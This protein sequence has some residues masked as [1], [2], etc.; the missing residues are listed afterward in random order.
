MNVLVERLNATSVRISWEMINNMEITNYIVYYRAVSNRKRQNDEQF[1]TVPSSQ[2]SVVIGD[3]ISNVNY[4]FEVAAVVQGGIMGQR[5]NI[6]SPP[7]SPPT[8]PPSSDAGGY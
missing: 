7:T 1:V 5:S 4:Q 6:A 3:L 2:N 8:S